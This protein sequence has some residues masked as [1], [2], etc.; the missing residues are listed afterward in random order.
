MRPV[1]LS[2]AVINGEKWMERQEEWP[3]HGY[4]KSATPIPVVDT[5]SDAELEELNDLLPWACFVADSHGRRFGKPASGSKR[6]LPQPMPDRRIVALNERFP[7]AE[8]TV[9]EIGC[10]E[11][12]HTTALAHLAKHVKACDSRIANVVKTA[13]RCAMFQVSPTLFV[14]DVEKLLPPGIDP[15]CDILHHVGVL[16]HLADP[17]SHLLDVAKYV[18]RGIMLDTHVATEEQADHSY[19]VGG[20]TFRCRDYRE[21]SVDQPFAGMYAVARWLT[22]DDLLGVLQSAG[23]PNVEVVQ[24]REERNG[25]R[26]LVYGER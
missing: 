25:L 16:Y 11:G 23:F 15:S 22:L 21:A 10:F 6:S 20:R 7:L 14:W 13:A 9:L 8:L 3:L 18:R 19:D 26:V 12:L 4:E 1:R 5:L 24:R 17:V 2:A